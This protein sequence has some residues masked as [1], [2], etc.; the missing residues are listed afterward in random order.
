MGSTFDGDVTG[1][2][3]CARFNPKSTGGAGGRRVFSTLVRL[4]ADNV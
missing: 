4:L 2:S 1:G 3:A